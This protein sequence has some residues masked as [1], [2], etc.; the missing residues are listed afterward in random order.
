MELDEKR[1]E[2]LKWMTNLEQLKEVKL[3]ELPKEVFLDVI[4][5][6]F[7]KDVGAITADEADVF[8]YCSL[9]VQRGN[10]P[11]DFRHPEHL[12]KR[13]FHLAFLY[14]KIRELIFLS[15][16]IVGLKRFDVSCMKFNEKQFC[17]FH[18]LYR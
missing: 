5:V 3:A 4:T 15:L 11:T 10:N 14:E 16:E 12:D 1:F 18:K 17:Q 2:L 7:M 9:A 8:L 13:A 6:A